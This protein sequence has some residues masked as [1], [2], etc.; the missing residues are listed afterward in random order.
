[1]ATVDAACERLI[2]RFADGADRL[3]MALAGPPGAGKSTVAARLLSYSREA[4][5]PTVVVP[6]DGWHLAHTV[7][8]ERGL[9]SVKGAPETFDA[10]GFINLVERIRAQGPHDAAIWAPEFRREIEDAVAGAIEIRSEHRLVVIEGNYLLL[11]DDPWRRAHQWYDVSWFLAP[12]AQTRRQ[13]LVAR[14]ELFGHDPAAALERAQGS[15]ERNARL[16]EERSIRSR[17]EIV[18]PG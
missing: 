17:A 5:I 18:D 1:M 4:S 3:V 15:D 12:P 2:G 14:H 7:V 11:D 6:M 9:A 8:T 13:R 10:E 16:V